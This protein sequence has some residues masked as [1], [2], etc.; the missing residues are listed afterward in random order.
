MKPGKPLTFAT[1]DVGKPSRRLLSFGLPGNPVS[2]IVTFS[3]AVLPS[4]RKMAGWQ[5]TQTLCRW[6]KQS[7]ASLL[8]PQLAASLP[9]ID[10]LTQMSATN[11][12][13]RAGARPEEGAGQ[14]QQRP[15]AGP[16]TARVPPCHSALLHV[17]LQ[18][19]D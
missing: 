8:L 5:V 1:L 19:Q 6:D 7:L 2:A 3:L 11:T 12:C 14:D 16:S 17:R 9:D 10:Q 15:Q 18:L 13:V 4:L